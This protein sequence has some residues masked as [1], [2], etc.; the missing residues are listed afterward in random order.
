MYK[1]AKENYQKHLSNINN[2]KINVKN[3]SP[4][5]I[6]SNLTKQ[7]NSK[8]D[9]IININPTHIIYSLCLNIYNTSK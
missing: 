9:I 8:N 1:R 2:G 3:S 7:P 6:K 5:A 4:I